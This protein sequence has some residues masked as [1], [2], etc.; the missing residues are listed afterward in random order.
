MSPPEP[1]PEFRASERPPHRSEEREALHP[2]QGVRNIAPT[3]RRTVDNYST[4][5]A[6]EMNPIP[7]TSAP[8]SAPGLPETTREGVL[9]R[10]QTPEIEG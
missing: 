1:P 6:L 2:L 9:A 10:G 4:E 3:G 8:S 5:K 7:E